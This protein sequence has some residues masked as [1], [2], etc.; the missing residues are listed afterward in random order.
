MQAQESAGADLAPMRCGGCGSKVG[1]E[2]LEQVLAQINHH[3]ASAQQCL[4][5]LRDLG[6]DQAQI[7]GRVV[8]ATQR[9]PVLSLVRT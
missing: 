6:Y 7:I 2:I 9:G 8:E 4:Q 1:S 3:Y 5:Q